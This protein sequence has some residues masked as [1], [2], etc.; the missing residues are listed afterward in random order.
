MNTEKP[1]LDASGRFIYKVGGD[2]AWRV[3]DAGD[4][5]VSMEWVDKQPAMVIWSKR[6]PDFAFAICLS[7]IGKYATPEGKPNP[8]GV[9]ELAMALPD[10]GRAIERSELHRL[11][12]VVLR[13]TSELI[14]MPPAPSEVL[15][16]DLRN[17]LWEVTEKDVQT[18]KTI[19]EIAY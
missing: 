6:R 2:Q 17:P 7:S 14:A 10:F 13:Y 3:H 15:K 12:D 11:V 19:S 8:E 9:E 5:V 18:G 4:Y 1:I 16:E